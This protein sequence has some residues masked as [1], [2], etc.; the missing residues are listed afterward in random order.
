MEEP[1]RNT[2]ATLEGAR[3]VYACM[4]TVCRR[5]EARVSR[6]PLDDDVTHYSTSLVAFYGYYF[7]TPFTANVSLRSLQSLSKGAAAV[8]HPDVYKSDR[9]VFLVGFVFGSIC[10]IKLRSR[11]G[12][13]S[14]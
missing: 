8:N 10:E 4:P 5:Y 13:E 7:R 12:N 9:V 2:K 14:I 3:R 11:Q 6:L 1:K